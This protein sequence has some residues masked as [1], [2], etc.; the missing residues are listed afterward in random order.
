[1]IENILPREKLIGFARQQALDTF[2]KTIREKDLEEAQSDGWKIRRKNKQS[3]SVVKP[4]KKWE[5]FDS[6]VWTILYRMGFTHMS[7]KGGAQL[8]ISP[9]DPKGPKTQIDVVAIDEEVALCVECKSFETPKKDPKFPERLAKHVATRKAFANAVDALLPIERKRHIAT[10]MFTFDIILTEND[11]KRAEEANAVLF[12]AHDLDYFEALVKHLGPAARYQFLAEVFRG[13]PIAGLEIRVPCVRTKMGGF[14]CYT[15]SIKPEYLLKV[16][17]IAHRAKGKAIDVDAYQRMISKNRLKKICEYIDSDG[18]F[19]TNIV[20]NVEQEKY[21]RFDRGKQEGDQSGALFGWLTLSPSYGAA[22]IIDGQ[23]RLFAYSGHSRSE[24]SHLSVLAFEGLPSSKQAQLFVDINSEQRAVKRSLLVE[25]DA[26]LKWDAEEEEKRIDAVISKTGLALDEDLDSPLRSRILLSDVKRT[27][28]R[29]VS[30]TSLASALDK[31]GFYIIK[32]HK[33]ITEY[34]PLWRANSS[35]CLR[36]TIRILKGWLSPIAERAQEWWS[37]GAAE[38]G[39]LA[40]NNGVTVCLNV[41][42]S[43]FEHLGGSFN[44]LTKSDEDVVELINPY[45]TALGNYFA[46]MPSE[47]R[48]QFRQLQ[49]VDGQTTGTRQCQEEL[50]KEFPKYEPPGLK[51]WIERRKANYNEQARKIIEEIEKTLQD[52]I[53]EVLKEEYDVEP[54]QWWFEG[55]PKAVRKKV[56]ERINESNGK[57]GTR[58]QNFDLI[59]Y[60]DIIKENWGLFG[61]IFGYGNGN[62]E[63]RTQWIAEVVN[64]R[65]TVMHPSRLEFLSLDKLTQLQRY[66]QWLDQQLS[67]R[68]C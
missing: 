39:G 1:M 13:R 21:I 5:N 46:R 58:E 27:D 36:R 37:L 30:L 10:I 68:S 22:W 65:N 54:E 25:L 7:G 8:V 55:V 20:I 12:D 19:P 17:Y 61:E 24:T 40:M 57:L 45:A 11:F 3:I 43:I 51:E 67:Q 26:T 33:G 18:I 28:T 48:S 15:F 9:S 66:K 41:L 63:K 16:A 56:D 59:H 53:L 47:E 49:G 6:R 50:Q 42:R 14:T 29:C 23:H 31:P 44:L 2:R 35:D 62:K 4:K 60:R 64:M 38:G 34:G 52:I 32:K